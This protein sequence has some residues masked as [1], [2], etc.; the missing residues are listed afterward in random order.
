MGEEFGR[1]EW[2][3]SAYRVWWGK[4]KKGDHLEHQSLWEDNI[5]MDFKEIR[6]VCV[7]WIYVTGYARNGELF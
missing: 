5:K 3:R 2:K 7:D 1:C 6:C 4:L